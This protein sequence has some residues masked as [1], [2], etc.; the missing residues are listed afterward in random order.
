MKTTIEK[1]EL[2]PNERAKSFLKRELKPGT[3][4]YH[5]IKHVASSG[6]SRSISFYLVIDKQIKCINW[7]IANVLDMKHDAKHGGLRVHGCGMDMGFSIVY[8]LG[9]AIYP[10]GFKLPKGKYGRNGDTSGFDKD[11]GYAFKSEWI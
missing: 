1:R 7:E 5:A 6:M 4:V 2:T 8:N 10:K 11:G 3:T 9:R